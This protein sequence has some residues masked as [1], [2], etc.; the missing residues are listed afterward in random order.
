MT[1]SRGFRRR[2]G[3]VPAVARSFALLAMAFAFTAASGGCAQ[4]LRPKVEPANFTE[5][6]QAGTGHVAVLSVALKPCWT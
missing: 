4:K 1:H 2:Q 6:W 3:S 5:Q